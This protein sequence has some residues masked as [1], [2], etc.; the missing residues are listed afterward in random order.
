[1]RPDSR[2]CMYE[3]VSLEQ[4]LEDPLYAAGKHKGLLLR[5]KDFLGKH[6]ASMPH[7]LSPSIY[8]SS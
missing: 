5:K 8:H 7:A 1:M 2:T 4:R 6:L 3:H